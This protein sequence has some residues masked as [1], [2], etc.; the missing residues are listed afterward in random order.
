M[1]LWPVIVGLCSSKAFTSRFW[2]NEAGSKQPFPSFLE[3]MSE[4]NGGSCIPVEGR[5]GDLVALQSSS[6]DV[7]RALKLDV[8]TSS[9]AEPLPELHELIFSRIHEECCLEYMSDLCRGNIGHESIELDHFL[10]SI[11]SGSVKSPLIMTDG[12]YGSGYIK[13]RHTQSVLKALESS[14]AIKPTSNLS[15]IL[16]FYISASKNI[17]KGELFD[18]PIRLDL[19]SFVVPTKDCWYS[20]FAIV[21][22]SGPEQS[23]YYLIIR[24]DEE[25]P[26]FR[27]C[28][29]RV[30]KLQSKIPFSEWKCHREFFCSAAVYIAEDYIDS[31]QTNQRVN[32][33][34]INLD[35][36]KST[37]RT[38]GLTEEQ[39]KLLRAI[40]DG[41]NPQRHD[42]I[43][44][45][46][47]PTDRN[48]FTPFAA[49]FDQLNASQNRRDPEDDELEDESK[50]ADGL[51]TAAND[52]CAMINFPG[53]LE[54][55]RTA[56][57][58][59][60]FESHGK[61]EFRDL[62]I[63]DLLGMRASCQVPS[64]PDHH[65]NPFLCGQ[66]PNSRRNTHSA[67][68]ISEAKIFRQNN[69]SEEIQ[70]NPPS[71]GFVDIKKTLHTS[72]AS[73]AFIDEDE[74]P[75]RLRRARQE[76]A[77][78]T[79]GR[80]SSYDF[81]NAS[82][83]TIGIDTG[84][85]DRV[86]GLLGSYRLLLTEA[87]SKKDSGWLHNILIDIFQSESNEHLKWTLAEASRRAVRVAVAVD[88][89]LCSDKARSKQD[90]WESNTGA[91]EQWVT[92]QVSVLW[93]LLTGIDNPPAIGALESAI[94]PFADIFCLAILE[95]VEF[96]VLKTALS[97]SPRSEQSSSDSSSSSTASRQPPFL[98]KRICQSTNK[99]PN[100]SFSESSVSSALS[101]SARKRGRSSELSHLS[102][103]HFKSH[104]ESSGPNKAEIMH[105]LYGHKAPSVEMQISYGHGNSDLLHAPNLFNEAHPITQP[106]SQKRIKISFLMES[107]ITEDVMG[108]H[109]HPTQSYELK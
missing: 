60:N 1:Q 90:W 51:S 65:H 74:R 29:S 9:L 28:D 62:T 59:L 81:D 94:T 63:D 93:D 46:L 47:T 88:S 103:D 39:I 25:S 5:L 15:D 100:S 107:E 49:Y 79:E 58:R 32:L 13:I 54:Q 27:V 43:P 34:T 16:F 26:W 48:L 19:S 23:G 12:S 6:V 61:T 102:N 86:S 87:I 106:I 11:I 73:P 85:L 8:L 18:V 92:R 4:E 53:K 20:L 52:E 91:L 82:D 70:E 35:L 108:S 22:K 37:L 40:L 50:T 68:N 72:F 56:L 17:K 109:V 77:S 30:E 21:I 67:R 71:L 55:A 99:S 31:Q 38:L 45:P 66:K 7:L 2:D 98:A 10:H 44:K 89:Y 42:N 84:Q 3:V 76:T 14:S 95:S 96:R 105:K 69:D 36:A 78:K 75:L 101:T 104:Y 33:F 97:A 41:P 80:L 24:P 83:S 57:R 64:N